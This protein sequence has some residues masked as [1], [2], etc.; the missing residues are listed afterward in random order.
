MRL[1]RIRR[2]RRRTARRRRSPAAAL[3]AAVLTVAG[4]AVAGPV[5]SPATAAPS[6]ATSTAGDVTGFTRSGNTYTATTSS[7]AKA[8]LVIARADIFRLW[9][10][11]DGSFTDDPAGTDLAPTTDFGS[12]A[13][14]FTD[15]GAYYRVTTGALSLRV[16]KSPLQFSVYRAD[17]TT[18]VWQETQP[19]AFAPGR[20]TQYLARGADEQFYGTGLRLGE[21]ALRGKTVPVA[22][23]NRWR[24]NDNASPAP[25]YMST[26]GYGVMR[27]T[28][29][30]G[31]YGFNAPSTLTHDENRFDAW[32]F[33]GDSLKSVL[34]AYT[35]VSGKPFMA[36]MWGFEL[37]NADCFNAS[38]PD[39]QGDHGRLRH[40]TTPDV[41]GYAADARAADMPSGWFLPNDGYGCGYTAPLKSTVDA[42]K[43]KGFQTGLWTS[44]GLGGIADEV[45]TAGSRGVKTDVAWI[46][47]G[48][49]YAFDGVQQAVD[50]IE[51]N[52][53]ARRYVWT[54]DG[55]A[56]TQRNA[57][58]WTGDTHGTWD[59]MRWHVPAIAGAGLSGLNYAAGDI[60]GIFGGSP[61][62]YT[63]DLQWK[64]FTPAFMTMS[65][66]GATGP[67]AGYHDKQPWR[68]AEPYLSI[69]R[70]YLQL[71]MRLMPYLYTMSRTAHESGVPSTRAM[72]LEYPDDPVARGN[73][74]SG[75]FMAGDSLL[76]APVVSDTTVRDGI[77]LPAGTWTDYWTGRTYAGPGWLNGYQAPLDT[78]PLFVKGGAVV[79]MWPQMNH[80]GEK[81]VSTLT[82]DIHPRGNSSFS[83]YEDDGLT[84]AHQSGA[85]ARQQVDVTAP[86]TGSGTVTVAVSAPTG[87]Y[88]GKPASRGYEFTLH[89]ASAPTALTSDGSALPRL[90]SK[91]AYEAAASGWFFDAS[92][93]SGVLWVKTGTKAGAF[94]VSATGTTLPTPQAIPSSAPIDRSAW[95]LVSADSQE[96]TGENGA[97]RNAFDGNPATLWHTAWSQGA[98]APL[99]HEL[100]IDLGSRHTVDGL[101]YLPRQ[102]G[103][104]NGRIGSYEVY[105]S[106][107]TADWG[108]PVATGSFADTA[109]VKNTALSAKAGRYLRLKA[110]TEAGARGPWT[111][112]AEITLTGRPAPL[113]ASATLVNA[114][115]TRCLD[116]PHSATAPGTEPTLY[117]CHGGPNQRWTLQADGRLTGLSGVCLDGA[118]IA[119]VTV[120]ACDGSAGQVWTA[121]A[122][123][124]LRNGGQCLTPVGSGTADGT[125]LTRA[126]CTDSA[127]QRWTFTP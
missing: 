62:T 81:P 3:L 11:P 51:K 19:T 110:L 43:A 45:A 94:S 83:L 73:A 92:D 55:W 8:R 87:S 72:V 14:S 85:Y 111:S 88:A 42:L 5:A 91:S 63:R 96:T 18:L 40:Q 76:V 64:A 95:S 10:S 79:P 21:W 106:D 78:L 124:S 68:F 100:Q 57:V 109:A 90:S 115:A 77:Y 121:G 99:P 122:Q 125:R 34:D 117:A 20:T 66:W 16:N 2:S 35:D 101:G 127:A 104:A 123:S 112:A 119:R 108:S 28:W 9:L 74:T 102:D 60:D 30:P 126:A 103:G 41:V 65:G 32:Y 31:S 22:V 54:V 105:V 70:K 53:D 47:S 75:Q 15:A 113:P 46:G 13:T 82:Y 118:R 39:Y 49:K 89:V 33:T 61:K 38:N 114:A 37:G 59:D 69:N 48:Y 6:G 1:P 58:V 23:D 24:E 80:T 44:T 116:L 97:A 4:L 93:R 98:P 56:G 17:N 26:N 84:R 7:G 36:P 27:N 52:S 29:A 12:V 50:G 67:S 120:Q 25:F 107:T 86:T 71:K